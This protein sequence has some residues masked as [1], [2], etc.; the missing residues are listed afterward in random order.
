MAD[1]P[2]IYLAIDNCFAS[3]RWTDPLD[4]AAVV[5][6]LG[7]QYVEASADN[8][9]DP[10]YTGPGYL[11]DWVAQVRQARDLTGVAVANFYSGHG[12]YATTGLTHT[13][14]RIR[15]RILNDW[16]KVMAALAAQ[17]GAGLGFACHAFSEPV[18]QDPAAYAAAEIDL[19]A[20][21]AE[22]ARYAAE[23]G[24]QS[25]GL[26][27][28]YTPHM[29]PWTL[30]GSAHLLREVYA[31]SGQP[32][33]LTIDTG[34]QCGQRRFLRP[35]RAQLEAALDRC[36][37]TGSLAGAWLGPRSAYDRLRAA[38]RAPA[39]QAQGYL[40]QA[41]AE[42]DRYPY[43]FAA[44]EDGDP[45]LW[46]ERLGAYSPIVHL[47]QTPGEKSAHQPFTARNNAAGIIH[48]RP[49]LEAL[50]RGYAAPPDPALPPRC[51][52]IYLTIEVF[53]GTGDLPVDLLEALDET[54][55]YWRRWVPR[56]GLR[57]EELLSP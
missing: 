27:Q 10:L 21:L 29:I 20:R 12:T 4:W 5:K 13:D 23:R 49:V 26:E 46:L 50:A 36:R 35:G 34:H 45:Y 40:E 19:Y 14:P 44:A 16:L 25:V 31:R 15:D 1:S 6:D 2:L 7:L 53:A 18:I 22:L 11:A 39:A 8:E 24:T 43:L 55:R 37:A 38:A 52:A 17:V 32:F 42:M 41:E 51:E 28:M 57:L 9:C 54:V 3:R 48:P 47:Q 56:D 33:Y 30:A